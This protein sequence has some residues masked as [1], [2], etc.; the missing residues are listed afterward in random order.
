MLEELAECRVSVS[1]AW[2]KMIAGRMGEV[3]RRS[4]LRPFRGLGIRRLQ[5]PGTGGRLCGDGGDVNGLQGKAKTRI[6][7]R[8]MP[9]L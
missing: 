9:C 7:Y 3:K 8:T 6:E 2:R 5:L 4:K 1:R